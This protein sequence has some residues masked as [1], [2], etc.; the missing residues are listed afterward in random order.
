MRS[1]IRPAIGITLC[2]SIAAGLSAILEG[3]S[4]SRW[5]PFITLAVIVFV[6][7]RFGAVAGVLGTIAAAI[8]FA[9]FLFAPK[10]SLRVDDSAQRSN[11]IWMVIAGIALSDLLGPRISGPKS[12]T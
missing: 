11:L 9:G 1:W 8:V 3:S 2:V 4:L 7:S 12:K 6:A 5:L 10:L